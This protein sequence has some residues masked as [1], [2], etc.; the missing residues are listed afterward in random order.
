MFRNNT[1]DEQ[2][3]ALVD[4]IHVPCRG[5]NL[6]KFTQFFKKI[7]RKYTDTPLKN[8]RLVHLKNHLPNKPP[9]LEYQNVHFSECKAH[10]LPPPLTWSHFSGE[11]TCLFEAILIGRERRVE[12]A[13]TWR[14]GFFL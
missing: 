6:K 10:K 5:F 13:K 4:I 2:I 12:V 11:E 9:F 7:H 14:F 8:E 3:L 1:V